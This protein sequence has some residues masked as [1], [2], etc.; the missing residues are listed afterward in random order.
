MIRSIPGKDK[1][2]YPL[3][4]VQTGYVTPLASYWLDTVG[5]GCSL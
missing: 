4:R 5:G 1:K 3:P 2:L